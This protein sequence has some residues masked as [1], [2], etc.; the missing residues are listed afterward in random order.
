[1]HRTGPKPDVSGADARTS[2]AKPAAVAIPPCFFARTLASPSTKSTET[3]LEGYVRTGKKRSSA[4]VIR[5]REI[6]WGA[7]LTSP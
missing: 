1:M 2:E 3:S 7:A 4:E 5:P 6:C